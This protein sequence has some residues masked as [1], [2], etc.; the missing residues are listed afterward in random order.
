MLVSVEKHLTIIYQILPSV[1]NQL[2]QARHG[3]LTLID[4]LSNFCA[5]LAE[6][7]EWLPSAV[8]TDS[9]IQF[10]PNGEIGSKYREALGQ[11]SNRQYQ[12]SPQQ[13]MYFP[14]GITFLSSYPLATSTTNLKRT[15]IFLFSCEWAPGC[16]L[17][18]SSFS[19]F[20]HHVVV[21]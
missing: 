9:W 15:I 7:L 14:H 21:L 11:N 3:T 6:R 10:L 5:R 20:H 13:R 18:L 12:H 8:Y 2:H 16:N 4:G 1:P 19:C 17:A